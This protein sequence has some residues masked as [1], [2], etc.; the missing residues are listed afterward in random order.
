M[1][2][3]MTYPKLVLVIGNKGLE[4]RHAYLSNICADDS[5]F[6][7]KPQGVVEPSWEVDAV[8]LRKS[9]ASYSTKFCR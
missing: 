4:G 2:V 1:A 8:H 7:N 5:C 3:P 6:S 9:Q